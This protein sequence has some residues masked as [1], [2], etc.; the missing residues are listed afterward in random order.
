MREHE[1]ACLWG[2][3]VLAVATRALLIAHSPFPWGYAWDPYFEGPLELFSLGRLPRASDCSQCYHPPL[4]YLVG[5]PFVWLGHAISSGG[6]ATATKATSIRCLSAVPL[7][8]AAISTWATFRLL[9]LFRWRGESLAWGVAMSLFLP[10]SF[11]ASYGIEADGLVC[12][13]V[14]VCSVELAR[15]FLRR[16]NRT[17]RNAIAVGALCGLALATKYSGA[18]ALVTAETTAL[19][20]LAGRPRRR[21]AIR[22]GL[23]VLALALAIGGW[24]Y[25]ANLREHGTPLVANGSAAAGFTVQRS[26]RLDRYRFLDFDLRA[27]LATMDPVHGP[28]GRLTRLDVYRSVPSAFYGLT[29][30]D[31]GF[32]SFGGRNGV[33]TPGYPRRA[34]ALWMPASVL[35]LGLV[36][37]VLGAVGAALSLRRRAMLPL[38]VL[39]A[40]SIAVYGQWML[41][42]PNWAIKPKYLTFLAPIGIAY[43]LTA[44]RWIERRLPSPWPRVA[45]SLLW[46]C[47]LA[48]V[49]YLTQFAIA[50]TATTS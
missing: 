30:T 1:R 25:V 6:S 12:A 20:R 49:V 18:V 5:W 46:L 3:V 44:M 33:S 42:Q 34:I 21:T 41:A 48:C 22:D 37:S 47:V 15:G 32:F 50:T 2:L 16:E 17:L 31:M 45:W 40:V 36:P 28:A 11:F 27:V 38:N 35:V 4:F 23:V 24:K 43:V 39:V 14:A 8:C 9:R 7:L 26:L 19:A 13:L 10:V 29:W